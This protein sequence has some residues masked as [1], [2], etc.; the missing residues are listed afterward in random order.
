VEVL[1]LCIVIAFNALIIKWKFEKKRYE[2]AY[3]D[4]ALNLLIAI[5]FSGTISGMAA[6]MIASM[7]ISIYFIFNPPTFFSKE[8]IQGYMSKL[9]PDVDAYTKQ[10]NN[11]TTGSDR[12]YY[13]THKPRSSI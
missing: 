13:N 2:D 4:I 12:K 8:N 7:L 5:M 3:F 10:S 1:I 11:T 9:E 6:G